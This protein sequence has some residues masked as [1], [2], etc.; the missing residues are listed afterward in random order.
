MDTFQ[1]DVQKVLRTK[2]PLLANIRFFVSWLKKTVHEEGINECLRVCGQYNGIAFAKAVLKFFGA[3]VEVI[4]K[5]PLQPNGR[6]IFAAN[7][8]LGGLDGMA[9]IQAISPMFPELR[10]PVNDLLLAI[11]NFQPIFMPINKLGIQNREA[12]KIIN[13]AYE[14]TDQQIL[15]F[16]AGLV[17]RKIK[18]KIVDL[19]WQKHFISK[20]IQYKRDVVP[21]YIDGR[22]SDRF[23]RLA[24]WR[25]RLGIK[26]NIEMLYLPDEMFRQKNKTIRITI[27]TPIPYTMLKNMSPQEWAD[28]VKFE[29]YSLV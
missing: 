15:M 1:I 12:V 25:K 8:P 4:N 5:V 27:G 24:N 3:K 16:P 18:G 14:S 26:V 28:F 23:Y 20:A 22:N 7:H 6:Y 9:L 21:V 2:S 29:A 13:V 11:E 17:P 19:D 10:F